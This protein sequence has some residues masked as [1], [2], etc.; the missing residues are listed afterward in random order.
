ME[1]VLILKRN[2]VKKICCRDFLEL[3][4]LTKQCIAF[5]YLSRA[6]CRL[7]GVFGKVY[8]PQDFPAYYSVNLTWNS[9]FCRNLQ[10]L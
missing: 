6:E 3:N 8:W 7:V 4:A 10:A 2:L 9:E 1:K 5:C